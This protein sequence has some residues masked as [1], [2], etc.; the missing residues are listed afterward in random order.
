MFLARLAA[1]GC[2][3]LSRCRE[4]GP[5]A[6]GLVQALSWGARAGRACRALSRR[7]RHGNALSAPRDRPAGVADLARL[8]HATFGGEPGRGYRH[9]SR[10][11]TPEKAGSP[12]ALAA[13]A[14]G[15]GI[16][17]R[18]LVR[19]AENS[20]VLMEQLSLACADLRKENASACTSST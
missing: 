10:P 9:R 15:R 3:W 14:L 19:P 5:S 18:Y 7:R 4:S 16:V 8:A 20:G 12:A 11:C 17:V 6:D 2:F 13:G 1:A